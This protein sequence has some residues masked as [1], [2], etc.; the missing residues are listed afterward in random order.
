MTALYILLAATLGACAFIAWKLT[1]LQAGK[2]DTEDMR[3]L[4]DMME[5][6]RREVTDTKDKLHDG[7]GKNAEGIQQRLEKTMELVNKQLYGMD[8]RIDK[9]VSDMNKR[10]DSAA[11][12]LG[13]VKKQYGT[14]EEVSRSIKDLHEAFKAP[15]LR[16]GFGERALVDLVS[17]VLPVQSYQA[18]HRFKTG[19]IVDLLVITT[20]GNIPI[21]AKFPLENYLKLIKT[22]DDD[23]VRKTFCSDVKKHIRDIAKK[24]ILPQEGTLEFAL[25]YVPSDSVMHEILINEELSDLAE[26]LHVFILSPHSFYYFLNIIRLA[27]QSQQFEENAQQ[28]LS[29]IRGIQQQSGKLGDDLTVLQKHLGNATGKL[30]EVQT[31]YTKL[32]M[33]IKQAGMIEESKAGKARE[34]AEVSTK[35]LLAERPFVAASSMAAAQDAMKL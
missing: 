10:L 19:E 1:R 17:R 23:G 2:Q 15:K 21:D 20:N 33:Q 5:S 35:V 18:Q 24:Y 6:L 32:D 31:G 25:M 14:V 7:M 8:T 30:G 27:Y 11:A 3:M 9:R 16:G 4:R 34:I 29:I 13:D 22:P 26:N 12:I 28:V